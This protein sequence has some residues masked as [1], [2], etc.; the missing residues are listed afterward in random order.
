[1][2]YVLRS[3]R[4]K[5]VRG[6]AF[7]TEAKHD[8]FR[9]RVRRITPANPR[10]WGTM[11]VSQVLHHLN[12]ACGSPLGFY[13]LP[14]E[15]NLVSRTLFRWML[16]DWFLQQPGA[17][18]AEGFKIPHSAQFNFSFEQ[19]QLLRVL[20]AAWDARSPSDWGHTACSEK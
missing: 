20:D 14:D 3:F 9:H 19:Q 6:M 7:F 11:S 10:Q 17:S 15:S 4:V 18:A 1:M 13:R 5:Q 8:E 12:L 2:K 16:V